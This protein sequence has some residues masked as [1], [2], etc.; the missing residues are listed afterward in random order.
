MKRISIIKD[1]KPLLRE[2]IPVFLVILFLLFVSM[3][4]F[5]YAFRIGE[6]ENS[7][8]KLLGFQKDSVEKIILTYHNQSVDLL[9]ED[10]ERFL[11]ALDSAEKT[12]IPD[13]HIYDISEFETAF[14]IFGKKISVSFCWFS[15][16]ALEEDLN[17]LYGPEHR[18]DNR[19]DISL[20]G[21]TF[22]H[23]RFPSLEMIWNEY[24]SR[25]SFDRAALKSGLM[26]RG[27]LDGFDKWTD[28]L[29]GR[30]RGWPVNPSFSWK[31][32]I[33]KSE[34]ILIGRYTGQVSYTDY[35]VSENGEWIPSDHSTYPFAFQ[36]EESLAGEYPHSHFFIGTR[37][38]YPNSYLVS[39]PD[40]SFYVEGVVSP[41]SERKYIIGEDYLI[42]VEKGT[43]PR[44]WMQEVIQAFLIEDGRIYPWYNTELECFNATPL[45]EVEEYIRTKK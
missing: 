12:E 6:S 22:H 36:I 26:R 27:E 14:I 3:V 4:G 42:L 31:D 2:Y 23:F 17:S 8:W 39:N 45:S 44:P 29:G 33:D 5:I 41:V 21:S 9:E 13:Q 19:F 34:M 40:G 35:M 38:N 32:L 20:D 10:K 37:T 43:D 30:P 11:T 18:Y 1:Q 16:I 7:I 28:E 25:L 15:G 24:N